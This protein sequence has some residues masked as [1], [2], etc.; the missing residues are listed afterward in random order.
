MSKP[1][2]TR[3]G[4]KA[5][6]VSLGC[7]KNR[8]DTEILIGRLFRAGYQVTQELHQ[9]DVAIVNTC[10]F[11]QESV[12]EALT[13]ITKLSRYKRKYGF[14]LVVTG[15]L[16][17]R[18]HKELLH[19]IPEIDA[20]V[21]V[22]GYKDIV[23]AV[24][25]AKNASVRL[26]ACDYSAEFY[27]NR[28]LTTGP[29][30]AYLRIAD[31]CDNNCSYCLIP[32]IRGRYRSRPMEDILAEARALASRGVKEI[33]LIAQDTTNYGLDIY[34]ER[35]LGDLLLRLDKVKGLEWIRL[36]YT[37]PAH[38]DMKLVQALKQSPKTLRYLDIPLQHSESRLL[39]SMHRGTD[40]VKQEVLLAGLR[41]SMPG[42]AVRTTFMT[43]FPGETKAES[44]A[45]L[46][47]IARQKFERLGVFAFSPEP[48]TKAFKLD[49]RVGGALKQKR[50]IELLALQQKISGAYNRTRIGKTY[51]VLVEGP[52]MKG[53][54]VPYRNGYSHYGR[55]YAEAP[56]VDGKI[57]I[58]TRKPL[59]PGEY[60]MVRIN[61]AWEYDLGGITVP[62]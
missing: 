14:R 12:E 7:S 62:K 55:S 27:N 17:Q 59:A 9:A 3:L 21:G 37:H 49:K 58:K 2:R 51:R 41:K 52:V 20:L 31:G 13:E 43:G 45:L 44:K 11:L 60:T 35:K 25:G 36:L 18:M 4:P 56:E 10:G 39:K 33:N 22:H 5:Y 53:S 47:F 29:G 48:G 32:N 38:Y 46:N 23:S 24:A 40:R 30:W 6:I 16:V 28:A 50:R 19:K 61:R 1:D 34:G 42:L 15:C 26:A 54:G 8:V 57:Y